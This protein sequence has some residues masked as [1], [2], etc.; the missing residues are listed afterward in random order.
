MTTATTVDKNQRTTGIAVAAGL[1]L[2]VFG[3]SAVLSLSTQTARSNPIWF[4]GMLIIFASSLALIAVV[5][6]WLG[7]AAPAEAFGLPAGSIRTLLAAGVM[8]LFA[9]FGLQTLVVKAGLARNRWA[10]PPLSARP[11][12]CRP[13][14]SATAS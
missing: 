11:P 6:R 13:R 9:V 12:S 3:F 14:P 7:L 1:L 5:F 10:M 2:L 8:V 4:I